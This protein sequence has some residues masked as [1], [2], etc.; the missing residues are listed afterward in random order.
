MQWLKPTQP[1]FQKL[2]SSR[3]KV[4]TAPERSRT[5]A[6]GHM[7]QTVYESA[8]VSGLR[9]MRLRFLLGT[10]LPELRP[11]EMDPD[12]LLHHCMG[13]ETQA[14]YMHESI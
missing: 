3:S 8:V 6:A 10:L 1:E 4:F 2:P 13:P 9:D 7:H 14:A 5:Y 11:L 12:A